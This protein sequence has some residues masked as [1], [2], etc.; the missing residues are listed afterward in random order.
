L[1]TLLTIATLFSSFHF[2][3]NFG[4]V[5]AGDTNL[6]S[7]G[8]E[9]GSSG[10]LVETGANEARILL[11]MIILNQVPSG[12]SYTSLKSISAGFQACK[13]TGMQAGSMNSSV[14]SLKAVQGTVATDPAGI[15]FSVRSSISAV[16]IED[17]QGTPCCHQKF[18]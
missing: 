6:L 3:P 18:L 13:L 14:H 8:G 10:L 15:A 4:L 17:V 16:G 1:E 11:S 7:A 9:V 5:G 2:H 12:D